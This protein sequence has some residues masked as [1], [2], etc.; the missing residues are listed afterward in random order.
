MGTQEGVGLGLGLYIV[1]EIARGHGGDVS[2]TSSRENGTT[3]ELLLPV[4]R[5]TRAETPADTGAAP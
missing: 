3:F 4:R 5:S 1:R 2:V